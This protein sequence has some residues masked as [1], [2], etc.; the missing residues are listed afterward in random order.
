MPR[1]GQPQIFTVEIIEQHETV[2]GARLAAACFQ[3][4]RIMCHQSGLIWASVED[5]ARATGIHPGTLRNH[6]NGRVGYNAPKG[7]TFQKVPR[8]LFL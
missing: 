3:G 1:I 5:A 8:E 2:D 6:L 4:D 7:L